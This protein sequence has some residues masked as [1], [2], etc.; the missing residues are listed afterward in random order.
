MDKLTRLLL[1]SIELERFKR[2]PNVNKLSDFPSPV[3]RAMLGAVIYKG[4]HL[5]DHVKKIESYGPDM[6]RLMAE[7]L[8]PIRKEIEQ[9]DTA[10]VQIATALA[11]NEMNEK[12]LLN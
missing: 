5:K 4:E 6:R 10:E 12:T 1:D 7:E 8:V 9:L 2:N 3:L 11:M